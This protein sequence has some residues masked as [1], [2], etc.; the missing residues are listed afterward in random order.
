MKSAMDLCV[1][2]PGFLSSFSDLL[3]LTANEPPW[4]KAPAFAEPSTDKRA[5]LP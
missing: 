2:Y 5:K 4:R 3:T 1:V